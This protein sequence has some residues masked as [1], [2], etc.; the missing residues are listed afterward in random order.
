MHVLN[1]T[2]NSS[3][4]SSIIDR[5]TRWLQRLGIVA[6]LSVLIGCESPEPVA[7]SPEAPGRPVRVV[8]AQAINTAETLRLPGALRS[9]ERAQLAF[10]QPGYLAERMV[11]RGQRVQAG[12]VLATQ[13]NPALQPSVAAA[14]ARVNE[15]RSRLN[16]LERDTE[17]LIELVERN[18]ASD[19][20]LEQTRANRDV[21]RAALGQ[22]EARRDEAR[23]QLLDASLRAPFDGRIVELMLEPG[24]F[25]AAGM[26]VLSINGLDSLEL[27]LQLPGRYAARL[28]EGQTIPIMRV[29]DGRSAQAALVEIGRA[30]PGR[31]AP[32]IA[33]LI[34]DDR[35]AWQAGDPVYAEL[36]IEG[37]EAL[38][39]PLTSIVN[40]GTRYSRV[41]RVNG[42]RAEMLAVETGRTMRG[43]AQVTG[44]LQPGDRVIVAG[45]AQLLDGETV[46]VIE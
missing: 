20:E 13:Y 28:I 12:D 43:W 46:R 2:P 24:D 1:R 23:N 33:Q 29:S 15:T 26:P 37:S 7:N 16:Q 39:I 25:A 41:F 17:R 9:T 31:T 3:L 35:A 4:S 5:T 45:Q 14:E 36:S 38:S 34:D 22:A 6:M 40:P 42:N 27:E 30:E 11:E 44:P 8:E 18:L 19:D 10:L 32:V 21:A